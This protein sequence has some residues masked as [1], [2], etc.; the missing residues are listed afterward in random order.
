VRQTL[1]RTAKGQDGAPLVL[2]QILA[3]HEELLRKFNSLGALFRT[4][5]VTTLGEREVII[6]RIA[7][8]ADCPFE[9]E[10]HK[11]LAEAA[12]LSACVIAAAR[13]G[14]REGLDA[15]EVLLLD[16]AEE[17]YRWDSVTETTWGSLAVEWTAEQ[18]IEL[19]TT[20]AFFRM[21][22][23]IIN[24]IGLRPQETW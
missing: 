13:G 18:V 21:A 11:P 1:E 6:L 9:F 12:G 15:K 14:W 3:H 22:A 19:I 5:K 20:A 8:L 24:A 2:F 16:V 7:H 4:S 10:Q 17:M 23:S